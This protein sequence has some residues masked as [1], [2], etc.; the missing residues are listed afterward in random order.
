MPM[1]NL[2]LEL[3]YVPSLLLAAGVFF[4]TYYRTSRKHIYREKKNVLLLSKWDLLKVT[5]ICLKH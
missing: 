2:S 4:V 3:L 1:P 5:E